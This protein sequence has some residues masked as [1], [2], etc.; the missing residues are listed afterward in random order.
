MTADA[1]A[2]ALALRYGVD[3][4]KPPRLKLDLPGFAVGS[5]TAMLFSPSG[6]YLL[7]PTNNGVFLWDVASGT[8]LCKLP[9][10]SNPFYFAFSADGSEL[11]S[12][13]HATGEIVRV[14]IPSG[15]VVA[16]FKADYAP[17]LVGTGCLG[18][19]NG[20]VLQL[21]A[22]GLFLM[23]DAT[24]GRI[25]HQRQLE[26]N[27]CSGEVYWIPELGQVVVVQGSVVNWRKRNEPCAVWRWSWPLTETAPQRVP[28]TWDLLSSRL[29]PAQ[30]VLLLHHQVDRGSPQGHAIDF[31][32]VRTLETRRRIE[33]GGV[34]IPN[35]TVSHDGRAW[36]VTTCGTLQVGID[37]DRINLPIQ[38]GAADFS[39]VA[40][41]VAVSGAL[42]FV[43]P[44]G[45]LPRMCAALQL[46]KDEEA[47][48]LR[49]YSRGTTW[50]GRV[51]PPRIV[52]YAGPDGWALEPEAIAG[53]Q[54]A[55]LP[56]AARVALGDRDGLPAALATATARAR[57]ATP[58][59]EGKRGFHAGAVVP[60]AGDW[61]HAVAVTF[62][63]DAI[64]LWPMKR[65]KDG[66]FVQDWY[67]VAA[68]AADTIAPE[69]LEAIEAMLA[70]K[71]K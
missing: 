60:P 67:P 44:R 37:D 65:R 12:R 2:L 32:D 71:R 20:H 7:V 46:A 21:G 9:Q 30:G 53:R 58:A 14:A 26:K 69:L 50:P 25:V 47:L 33:C 68:I 55:P 54:Y 31:V 70:G 56:D 43:A 19:G 40:D 34:S 63:D 24:S 3:L 27:V 15:E 29:L 45:E 62:A 61:T 10:P 64:D 16:R 1:D 42:G 41:L 4:P 18:P 5:A 22:D 35:P 36:A 23:L 38:L 49:G 17:G 52:V 51:L 28:G 66:N 6:E 57:Q 59:P 48:R 13:G 39:P 11:L 8:R